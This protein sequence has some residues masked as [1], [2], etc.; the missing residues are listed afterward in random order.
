MKIYYS[1][2]QQD[3][4]WNSFMHFAKANKA[5]C[6]DDFT[7]QRLT[8]EE[9]KTLDELNSVFSQ[10]SVDEDANAEPAVVRN[11]ALEAIKDRMK[12]LEELVKEM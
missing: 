4:L 2:S 5:C 12:K 11:E 10:L 9:Q 1:T 6:G 3:P 8:A 7:L